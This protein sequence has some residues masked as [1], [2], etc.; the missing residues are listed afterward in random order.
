[1][2]W[3]S[4]WDQVKSSY[5]TC[6]VIPYSTATSSVM[7]CTVNWKCQKLNLRK[8]S[9]CWLFWIS[10][11]KSK[12]YFK[13]SFTIQKCYSHDILCCFKYTF[14][15]MHVP[16][17]STGIQA[18][19]GHKNEDPFQSHVTGSPLWCQGLNPHGLVRL[20]CSWTSCKRPPKM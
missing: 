13:S 20:Y 19:C 17:S 14:S 4:P 5:Q 10:C 15:T 3:N 1:M 16:S 7:F 8:I 18:F 9:L 2:S 12:A 11:A 6:Q